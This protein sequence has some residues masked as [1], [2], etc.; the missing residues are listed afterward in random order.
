MESKVAH[1]FLVRDDLNHEPVWRR[2]FDGHENRYSVHVHAKWPH[3]ITS[4]WLRGH[5]IPEHCETEYARISLVEAELLLLKAALQDSSNQYF[6]LHSESCIPLRSFEAAYQHLFE[7]GRSRMYY[8]QANMERHSRVN[9]SVIGREHFQKAS[10]FFCLTRTHAQ[11]VVEQLKLT[12]WTQAAHCPDEHCIPTTLSMHGR[13]GECL[14]GDVTF[15]HWPGGGQSPVTFH[16]LSPDHLN[17]LQKT[18][19]L[20]ARKFARDSDIAN[21]VPMP[22][23]EA[24]V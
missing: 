11:L 15:T 17:L 10:Q 8:H 3:Q 5:L 18:S 7:S 9:T 23:P 21:Q 1:L 2:Y 4:D 14:R 24:D 12:D 22:S 6:V 16:V 20:F 13:L 19:A